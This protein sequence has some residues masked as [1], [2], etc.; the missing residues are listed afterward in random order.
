MYFQ[1]VQFSE[2]LLYTVDI[3]LGKNIVIQVCL[4]MNICRTHQKVQNV[5]ITSDMPFH[6]HSSIYGWS[7]AK[8]DLR[9]YA[10]SV[11]P[12]QQPRLRRRV[13]SGS[14]LFDNHDINGSYFSCYVNNFIKYRCWSTPC[15]I[16]EGPFLCDAGHLH[17]VQDADK[18]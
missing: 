7:H 13:W 6:L 8:R 2:N 5:E 15:E 4:L 17:V 10:K 12:D 3:C 18:V 16:S 1:I 9:T 11:D 14:A